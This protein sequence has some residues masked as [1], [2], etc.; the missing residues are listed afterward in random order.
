[1]RSARQVP[2][3]V[4]LAVKHK[5]PLDLGRLVSQAIGELVSL[6]GLSKKLIYSYNC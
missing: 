1:M 6:R 2:V 5:Y 4:G 3:D